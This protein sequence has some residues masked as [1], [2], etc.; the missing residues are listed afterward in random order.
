MDRGTD[1]H[2][3]C[4]LACRRVDATGLG[5][6][7]SEGALNDLVVY[8]QLVVLRPSSVGPEALRVL[9]ECVPQC[10]GEEEAR[11][12]QAINDWTKGHRP[13]ACFSRALYWPNPRAVVAQQP[14]ST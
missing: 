7:P 13:P 8:C 11:R 1:F 9:Q 2:G 4:V 6:C 5:S 12:L 14:R 3:A 10:D